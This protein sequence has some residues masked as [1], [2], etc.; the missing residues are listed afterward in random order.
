M[1]AAAPCLHFARLPEATVVRKLPSAP[2]RS[3]GIPNG[4]GS[5]CILARTCSEFLAGSEFLDDLLAQQ[6]YICLTMYRQPIYIHAEVYRS[7]VFHLHANPRSS[8]LSYLLPF[9]KEKQR[10]AQF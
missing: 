5:A 8:F 9:N 2:G 10:L 3:G 7:C 6:T 1:N 4:G